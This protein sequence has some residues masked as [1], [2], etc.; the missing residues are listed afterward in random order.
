LLGP[1]FFFKAWV[2]LMF[3]ISLWYK[4]TIPLDLSKRE[5][6]LFYGNPFLMYWLGVM[7][8]SFIF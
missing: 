1:S 3:S 4:Y 7:W 6:I 8:Q 2:N 5:F